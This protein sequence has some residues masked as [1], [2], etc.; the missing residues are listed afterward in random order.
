MGGSSGTSD[1]VGF[2]LYNRRCTSYYTDVFYKWKNE[3]SAAK[4]VV[5][6]SQVFGP[7]VIIAKLIPRQEELSC[8]G[9]G[10]VCW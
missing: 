5:V 2:L 6:L 1:A 9:A 4:N 3:K 10:T 8:L 7:M